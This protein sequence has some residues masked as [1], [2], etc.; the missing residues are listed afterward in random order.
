MLR[1][2]PWRRSTSIH[3]DSCPGNNFAMIRD[4][5]Y[6]W[7]YKS[8]PELQLHKL[9]R[10]LKLSVNCLHAGTCKVAA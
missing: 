5:V 2:S 4:S 10:M 8:T 1:R 9:S 7:E 6:G 3:P